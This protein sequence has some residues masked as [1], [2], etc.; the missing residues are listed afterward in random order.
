MEYSS[1][2]ELLNLEI[3]WNLIALYSSPLNK[4][5]SEVVEATCWKLMET[6]TSYEQKRFYADNPGQ[7][8]WNKVRT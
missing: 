1:Y 7:I 8:I 3:L 5:K 6:R 4:K 2:I